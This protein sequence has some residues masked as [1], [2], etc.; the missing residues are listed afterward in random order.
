MQAVV[1]EKENRTMEVLVTSVSPVQ[2]IGGKVL[3]IVAVSLTQLVAWVVVGVL[4]VVMA[5]NAGIAW[6]QDATLDWG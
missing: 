5:S 2:F 3:G 6:F 4:A 1:E